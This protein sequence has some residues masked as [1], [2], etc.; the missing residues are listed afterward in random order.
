MTKSKPIFYVKK[1]GFQT[2]FQD[3]GRHG[4]QQFGV[5]TS[6]AMDTF[7]LRVANL[8]VGNKQDEAAMEITMIGPELEAVSPI[9]IAICGADLSPTINGQS[10]TNWKTFRMKEGDLLSFGIPKNGVRTYLAV[11]GGFDIPVVLGSKSTYLRAKL[12]QKVEKGSILLGWPS[13]N[14]RDIGLK[15]SMIPN[16]EREAEVNYI[17]DPHS[18]QFTKESLETF[19]KQTYVVASQSDRMGYRLQGAPIRHQNG[20]D[21]WSSAVPLGGIQVPSN[22]QPIILMADRQTTGGYTRIATVISTDIPKVAQLPPGGK[23]KF[24]PITIKEAHKKYVEHEKFVRRIGIN[25]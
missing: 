23:I 3:L 17:Q 24:R 1:P 6:G 25:G 2:T 16:Y 20:A 13:T 5:V 9:T 8:L 22:G 14:N 12:G 4:F 7:S 15:Q 11:K 10:I 21:I 19:S 18:N